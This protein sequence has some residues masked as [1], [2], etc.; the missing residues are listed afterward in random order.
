LGYRKELQR[1]PY[2]SSTWEKRSEKVCFWR[3]E[4]GTFYWA[5]M[6]ITGGNGFLGNVKKKGKPSKVGF[7]R[8]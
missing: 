2:G 8:V 3:L 6:T 4:G 1:H 7:R 5:D